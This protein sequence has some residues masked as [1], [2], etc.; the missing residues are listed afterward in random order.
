[1]KFLKW[2]L[3]S[4]I[5]ILL[6]VISFLGTF[7]VYSLLFLMESPNRYGDPYL[8]ARAYLCLSLMAIQMVLG[9]AWLLHW[10]IK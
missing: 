10:L 2:I 1:M 9:L 8:H 4:Y 6:I 3:T 5:S 7:Y